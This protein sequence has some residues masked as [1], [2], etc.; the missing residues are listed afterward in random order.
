MLGQEDLL[1]VCSPPGAET[2]PA[3]LSPEQPAAAVRPYS[4]FPLSGG[5]DGST[6]AT[7]SQGQSGRKRPPVGCPFPQAVGTHCS[8]STKALLSVQPV[9]RPLRLSHRLS[10]EGRASP[11]AS[12][13]PV[14]VPAAQPLL[15]T[16]RHQRCG[17]P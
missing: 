8:S 6:R 3:H 14:P 4:V 12:K 13:Y 7:D 16:C 5:S 9:C 1:S 10:A 11:Y 15:L 2:P 17:Y